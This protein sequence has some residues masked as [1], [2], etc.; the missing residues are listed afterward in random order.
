MRS[1]R[2]AS[3][4]VGRTKKLMPALQ[5]LSRAEKLEPARALKERKLRQSKSAFQQDQRRSPTAMKPPSLPIAALAATAISSAH[6][7]KPPQIGDSITLQVQTLACF[8]LEN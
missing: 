2:R 6:A 1:A 8:D 3:S 4:R 7:A 5:S